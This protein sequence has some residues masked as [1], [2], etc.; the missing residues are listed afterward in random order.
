MKKKIAKYTGLVFSALLLLSA[1]GGDGKNGAAS[2]YSLLDEGTKPTPP[3]PSPPTP[4]I[5][6]DEVPHAVISEG[7]YEKLTGLG[8]FTFHGDKSWDEDDDPLIYSWIFYKEVD[9]SLIE[10]SAEQNDSL[11]IDS[12]GSYVGILTVH[13]GIIEEGSSYVVYIKDEPPKNTPPIAVALVSQNVVMVDPDRDTNVLLEGSFSKDDGLNDPLIY[14]WKNA[15]GILKGYARAKLTFSC[16]DDWQKCYDN[17]TDPKKPICT[18]TNTLTVNDGEF[19]DSDSVDVSVDYSFCDTAPVVE[20]PVA[21]VKYVKCVDKP[22]SP[23]DYWHH[24]DGSESEPKG[25]VSYEW[26]VVEDGSLDGNWALD[27]G[28]TDPGFANFKVDSDAPGIG[29][30]AILIKLT[31]RNSAGESSAFVK[32]FPAAVCEDSPL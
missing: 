32:P 20:P 26:E 16:S 7:H 4:P 28:T 12:Y 31:V 29:P 10:V 15:G 17:P 24:L 1:C 18:Y 2:E 30:S 13:D 27:K 19:T 3:L 22:S 23:L 14:E 11:T 9:G 8:T 21:I 5:P 25:D 6:D